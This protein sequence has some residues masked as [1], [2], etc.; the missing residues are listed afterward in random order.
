MS[1]PKYLTLWVPLHKLQWICDRLRTFCLHLPSNH[2]PGPWKGVRCLSIRY[3]EPVSQLMLVF[4]G[5]STYKPWPWANI[6][7]HPSCQLCRGA[8]STWVG[9][10]DSNGSILNVIVGIQQKVS[11]RGLE[12]NIVWFHCCYWLATLMYFSML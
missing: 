5:D 7:K 10:R 12:N 1:Q 11:G 9:Q 2:F 6:A 8:S 3:S 4:I